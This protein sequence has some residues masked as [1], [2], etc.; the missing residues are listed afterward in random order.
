MFQPLINLFRSRIFVTALVSA[1]FTVIATQVEAFRPYVDVFLPLV[2][3][4]IIAVAGGEIVEAA[5]KASIETE[6]ERTEQQ[7]IQLQI[8]QVEFQTAQL[9]HAA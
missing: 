1:I 9:Q 5:G 6:R 7:R 2:V 8:V 4:A 3:T